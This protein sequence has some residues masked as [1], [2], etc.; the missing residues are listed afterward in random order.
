[1]KAWSALI[2]IA[3]SGLAQG[4]S[5]GVLAAGPDQGQDRVH[6]PQSR[7]S[8]AL[9]VQLAP[10]PV[11]A[12][13]K[14]VTAV[15]VPIQSVLPA[16]QEAPRDQRRTELRQALLPQRQP[17]PTPEDAALQSKQ[18][19]PKERMEMRQLLRQQRRDADPAKPG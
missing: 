13:P 19:S 14:P 17:S 15:N 3:L 16:A 2:T 5:A 12:L 7:A 11:E 4:V 18:L 6:V 10:T 8:R 1:M 9:L